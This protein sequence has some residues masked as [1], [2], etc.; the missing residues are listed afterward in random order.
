MTT[1]TI[2]EYLEDERQKE[3]DA[4][5]RREEETDRIQLLKHGHHRTMKQPKLELQSSTKAAPKA[6]KAA[7]A[8]RKTS[9]RAKNGDERA[10]GHNS[11]G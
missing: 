5:L 4:Q 7:K 1:K 11:R 8:S 3:R 10:R 6:R 9:H 2:P